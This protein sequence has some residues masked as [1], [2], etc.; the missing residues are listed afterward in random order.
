MEKTGSGL[1]QEPKQDEKKEILLPSDKEKRVE[2][3][4]KRY[5]EID[6]KIYEIVTSIQEDDENEKEFDFIFRKPGTLSFRQQRI[7]ELLHIVRL[8]AIVSDDL[9]VKQQEYFIQGVRRQV[10]DTSSEEVDFRTAEHLCHLGKRQ[11]ILI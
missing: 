6:G 10:A 1:R 9:P 11:H 2:Q 5:K 4:R 3:L 8:T 7:F